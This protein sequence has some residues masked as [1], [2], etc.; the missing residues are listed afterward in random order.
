MRTPARMSG[1][2]RQGDRKVVVQSAGSEVATNIVVDL[3]DTHHPA[4]LL[5]ASGKKTIAMMTHFEVSPSPKTSTTSG[6][7][8]I[9]ESGRARRASA[10][11]R[12]AVA[13]TGQGLVHDYSG[14]C[15]RTKPIV[16]RSRLIAT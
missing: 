15:P 4:M 16:V 5:M 9:F 12:R 13:R 10:R 11:A 1:R 8:A 2:A 7:I 14:N 3:V 6:R